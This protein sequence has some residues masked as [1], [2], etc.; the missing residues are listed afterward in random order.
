MQE[1]RRYILDILRHQGQIT[2]DGI[3]ETLRNKYGKDI[4]PVT[5]RHHLNVLQQEGLITE[6]DLRHRSTPGRPQHVYMLTEKAHQLF[7]NNYQQ[8]VSTLISQLNTQL[9]PE[10]TNVIFEGVADQMAAAID[11]PDVGVEQRMDIVVEYLTQLGYDAYWENCEQGYTLHTRN[12]PY[13]QIAQNNESLCSMDLRLITK[14]IGVVPRRVS[15]V[16]QGD[17]SCAYLIPAK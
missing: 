2:V 17:T 10:H 15:L 9:S 1:T 11:I 14:L 13:H 6:P 16:S 8:L 12:C 4:T 3:V 5:V 7:P